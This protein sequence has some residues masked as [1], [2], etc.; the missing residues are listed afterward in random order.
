MDR[1]VR[2]DQG[3][4]GRVGRVGRENERGEEEEEEGVESVGVLCRKKR[5]EEEDGVKW[6]ISLVAIIIIRTH[7]LSLRK[8]N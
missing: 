6:T 4:K 5:G 1:K 3:T 7:T 2:R 8:E